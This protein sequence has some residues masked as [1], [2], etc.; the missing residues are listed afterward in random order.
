MIELYIA[1]H[2][3]ILTELWQDVSLGFKLVENVPDTLVIE[4]N[5]CWS[6]VVM[7]FSVL[8]KES[9]TFSTFIQLVSVSILPS[10]DGRTCF[11]TDHKIIEV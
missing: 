1:V 6:A 3:N 5:T 8:R 10:S 7:S 2:F 4:S 11:V 9:F